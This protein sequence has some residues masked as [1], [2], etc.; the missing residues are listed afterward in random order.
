MSHLISHKC[1]LLR[2]CAYAFFDWL[3]FDWLAI[4][5][6][7]TLGFLTFILLLALWNHLLLLLLICNVSS[8]CLVAID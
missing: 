6:L 2:L 4:I 7:V 3:R 1:F 8:H 5:S